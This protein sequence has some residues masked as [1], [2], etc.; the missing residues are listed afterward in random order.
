[1][2]VVLAATF[3]MLAAGHVVLAGETTPFDR[4][5]AAIS[6]RLRPRKSVP[7]VT[8]QRLVELSRTATPDRRGRLL[9]W[10]LDQKADMRTV[11]RRVSFEGARLNGA[12]LTRP[13]L[14]D[15]LKSASFVEAYTSEDYQA[16]RGVFTAWLAGAKLKGARLERVDLHGANLQKADLRGASLRG[17]NLSGAVL[18]GAD[19]RGA[20]LTG[21]DFRR[22]RLAGARLDGVRQDGTKWQGA[23]LAL[24][25]GRKPAAARS[26]RPD[27]D[28]PAFFENRIRPLLIARCV[29]CHGPKKAEGGLRLDSQRGLLR[30]GDGGRVV[31]PGDPKRSSLM[32]AV[33]REGELKMPPEKPLS[34]LEIADLL[35]WIQ[36]G[37]AWPEGM[38]LS[39]GGPTLRGGPITGAERGFWSF[40][41]V[42][43]PTPPKA[44]GPGL[45]NDIDRFV[46]DRLEMAGLEAAP[47]ADRRTLIRRAT[48]DL[49]GLPPTPGEIQEFVVDKKPGAFRRVVDRLLESPQYGVRW[50]RHWLDVV[51]YADTAGET[52]DFPTPLSYMYRNWVVDAINDDLPYDRFLLHQLAGDLIA[53]ADKSLGDAD[54]R[55]LRIATGFVAISRRFGFNSEKYHNLTIQDTID[56]LG[57]AVLGLSLGC[58]RCHDH[59]YDPVN[60]EDYYSWYGI[61]E[62]TRY[63]FPGSEEKKKPY[64][65]YPVVRADRV[66][67]AKAAYDAERKKL[68]DEI[69]PLAFRLGLLKAAFGD[70]QQS[71]GGRKRTV[72]IS[73]WRSYLAGRLLNQQA[74]NRN[75]HQGFHVWHRDNLPMIGV[76]V[77]GVRL[78]VPGDVA[79]RSLVVHP[80]EKDGVG[81]AWRSP[82][83]GRVQISGRITDQHDCGDSVRWHIDRLDGSGLQP[84]ASAGN[85]RAGSTPIFGK[86]LES[87]DV[88]VGDYLQ[89]VLVPQ[90]NHGCDLTRVELEIRENVQPGKKPRR[91]RLV[92]DVIDRFHLSNPHPGVGES[93]DVWSFFRAQVDRG[94]VWAGT[95]DLKP[96]ILELDG[97]K[98]ALAGMARRLEVLERHRKALALREPVGM[99]YGAIDRDKPADARIQVRGDRAKLGE[100]VVR[101]NLEIL[102]GEKLTRPTGSGRLELAGWLTRDS[103]PL[104]PRVMANRIWRGHFG[105]GLVATENDFGVRG[106]RPS[107]PELLDWL[108]SRF[109]EAKFS[110]KRIHRLI[111]NSGAYRRSS[112][113]DESAAEA[114]PD[115]RLLWRFN[116]RRLSA[117]EIRDSILFVSGD[118]D[119]SFGGAHPF[120]AEGSWTSFS[121]HSPFYGLYPSRRRSLFLMQQRLKRHPFL[122]LFDGADPNVS[123]P[124]RELT[125]VPTQ[126]LYL[127]NS[128]FVHRQS[129]ALAD[130]VLAGSASR[131]ERL[132]R[133]WWMTLGRAASDKERLE[134]ERFL[135]AYTESL[136]E[137]GGD[138]SHQMA[139]AA[140]M[141]T[142]LTRNE[143]LFVD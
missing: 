12:K 62:S 82:I 9:R 89:L 7:P 90:A 39:E 6:K 140:L 34:R 95:T 109:L 49:T 76:N 66:E 10:M 46:Q 50:G 22:A 38:V 60:T 33:R 92:P 108:A 78:K 44:D 36:R 87:V 128:E 129:A 77:S 120:P 84:L 51:R 135:L 17:A 116:R 99:H 58:A 81:I 123:T 68:D 67:S 93:G 124:R 28:S 112:R 8:V 61:F 138:R 53:E 56:T 101:R 40:Q 20:D 69:R 104:M 91:W 130:R 57:Q 88:K 83:A 59:K 103:N 142:L 105:R 75:N 100:A 23:T 41:P 131:S 111:M 72:T 113:F 55:R 54:Y 133:G 107:H 15:R 96:L 139:W 86:A 141:R 29:K 71:P 3:G 143:F 102:G 21:A 74:R 11:L 19:L 106:E 13:A 122:A 32:E 79:P 48:F 85:K 134:A 63:S 117:E 64:D 73:P 52:A 26:N 5:L 25:R 80:A 118:L 110:V 126:S 121:Q 37:A 16:G 70:R 4:E 14:A 65:L 30:G 125:T 42:R 98:D 132:Q 18:N 97:D 31:V 136:G 24:A 27:A 114:D 47:A 115:A 43:D 119:P 35:Q 94:A 2:P 45:R 137:A 1:L 127:M